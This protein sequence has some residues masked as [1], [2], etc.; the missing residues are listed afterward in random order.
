MGTHE[1]VAANPP[2]ESI[3]PALAC[4]NCGVPLQ[5][6]YCHACGQP[7]KGMIR[8]L[9]S[10]MADIGDTLFNVDSRIFRTLVPLYL[11]PGF[12]T[13]EYLAGRRTRYVTPFRLF[14]FLCILAFFAIQVS[15]DFG[16]ID[17][18][19]VQGTSLHDIESAQTPEELAASLQAR[20]QAIESARSAPA[21]GTRQLARLDAALSAT[22]AA[23]RARRQ[24]LLD[25]ANAIANGRPTPADPATPAAIRIDGQE[26]RPTAQNTRVA[27][28]PEAVNARLYALTLRVRDNL[29]LAKREPSHLVQGMF[30]V[31]PQTMFVLMPFLALLLKLAYLFKRR[32][33]MEHLMVALHSH[34]FAFLSL[35]LLVL[36]YWLASWLGTMAAWLGTVFGVL[37]ALI[38]TWLFVYPFLMAKRVYRQGWIM[39]TLKF[40][41]VGLCYLVLLTLGMVGATIASLATS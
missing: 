27:W 29:L 37:S 11:R 20:E 38:W 28:L 35:L 31:L 5:G 3:A 18:D 25:R 17:A 9:A 8:H 15:F 2:V 14:F 21:V 39:T 30:A 1:P 23:A 34:A 32:L 10:V 26:W 36:V 41:W 7:V 12:L 40:M 13:N 19:V 6:P 4:G 22:R 16:A 24:F 33:Y